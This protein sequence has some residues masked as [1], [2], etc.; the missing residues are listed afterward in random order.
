[1]ASCEKE[2]R[3]PSL[4]DRRSGRRWNNATNWPFTHMIA[5]TITPEAYEA[6]VSGTAEAPSPLGQEGLIRVWLDCKF[7]DRL[8]QMR[9]PE[10]SYSDVILRL[11]K[12]GS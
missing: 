4:F 9:G 7:V 11:A 8:G 10:D 5:I 1:V 3:P 6:I 12:T 2:D